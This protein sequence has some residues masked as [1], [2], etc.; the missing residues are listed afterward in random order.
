MA[1]EKYNTFIDKATHR[2]YRLSTLAQDRRLA[3]SS[4]TE[5]GRDKE[6]Q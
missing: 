6:V 1:G 4:L 5:T 3:R 2:V